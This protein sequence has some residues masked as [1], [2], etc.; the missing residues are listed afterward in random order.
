MHTL[1]SQWQ[2]IGDKGGLGGADEYRKEAKEVQEICTKSLANPMN[3][4]TNILTNSGMEPPEPRLLFQTGP[5]YNSV[6]Q[7]MSKF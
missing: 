5:I 6:L 3:V 1:A 7:K 4:L 2:V